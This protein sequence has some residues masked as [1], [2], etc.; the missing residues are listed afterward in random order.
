MP[1]VTVQL[2]PGRSHQQKA[3]LARAITDAVAKIAKAAPEG[4]SVL[5]Q[6]VPRENWAQGG[7]LMSDKQ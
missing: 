2:L 3:E 1:I 5:F 4:T 7:V 6:E